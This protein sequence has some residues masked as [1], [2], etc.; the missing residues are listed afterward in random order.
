MGWQTSTNR[1]VLKPSSIPKV[2]NA[3]ERLEQAYHDEIK[4]DLQAHDRP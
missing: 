2:H 3:I 1:T 4:K